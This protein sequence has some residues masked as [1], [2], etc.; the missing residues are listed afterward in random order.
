MELETKS[1]DLN[2]KSY[3]HFS[4]EFCPFVT[5]DNFNFLGEIFFRDEEN[6]LTIFHQVSEKQE[7][8]SR[9]KSAEQG[10]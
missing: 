1:D 6:S 8:L 3:G 7:K 10:S 2:D 4:F 9:R 5:E